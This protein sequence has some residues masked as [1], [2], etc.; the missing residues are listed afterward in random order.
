MHG[1]I[2]QIRDAFTHHFQT[3]L[4]REIR[5]VFAYHKHM[6]PVASGDRLFCQITMTEGKRVGIHH[7]RTDTTTWVKMALQ[8]TAVM[9]DAHRRVFHQYGHIIPLHYRIEATTAKTFSI[10]WAGIEKQ[11]EIAALDRQVFNFAE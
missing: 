1:H 2:R 3:F 11:M 7:D 10:A 9:T 4:K 5:H 6:Q 8:R